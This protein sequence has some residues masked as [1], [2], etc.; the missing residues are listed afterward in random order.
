MVWHN[1]GKATG[2]GRSVRLVAFEEADGVLLKFGFN[3]SFEDE[4]LEALRDAGEA[5][6]RGTGV[7]RED[8]RPG[9]ARPL[10]GRSFEARD[11]VGTFRSDAL[12]DILEPSCDNS[13]AAL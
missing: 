4:K 13:F 5:S 11:T 7:L 1:T 10:C 12:K 2:P 8:A 6:V 9:G 3:A